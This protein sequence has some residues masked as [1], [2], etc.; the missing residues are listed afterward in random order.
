MADKIIE[1]PASASKRE[2]EDWIKS[3]RYA[4]K[5]KWRLLIRGHGSWCSTMRTISACGSGNLKE[6]LPKS[7]QGCIVFTTR[8]KKTAV[9]LVGQS[10]IEVPEMDGDGAMQLLQKSVADPLP[11]T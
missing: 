9:K 5:R 7:K 4:L 10:F 2:H 11:L 8:D 1:R 3:V 6:Y